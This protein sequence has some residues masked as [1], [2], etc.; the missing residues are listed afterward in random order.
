[1]LPPSRSMSSSLNHMEQSPIPS[2]IHVG[3]SHEHFDTSGGGS[4]KPKIRLRFS[5]LGHVVGK[6]ST[7]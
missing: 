2:P 4:S 7:K 5:L 6:N 3:G 1:M